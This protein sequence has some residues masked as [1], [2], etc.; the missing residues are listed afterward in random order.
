MLR[1]TLLLSLL[2]SFSSLFF[3]RVTDAHVLKSDGPI[4]AVVHI[5]PN[6]D[7]IVGEAAYFFFDFNDKESKFTPQNCSCLVKISEDGRE[8]FTTR[9]GSDPSLDASSFSYTFP[10]KGI[11]KITV[12][13]NSTNA[14]SFQPFTLE[15]DLRV[16]RESETK[17]NLNQ[18]FFFRNLQ[19]LVLVAIGTA[20]LLALFLEKR[21]ENV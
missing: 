1:K 19:Y 14:V 17:K 11:Y 7:P 15:Y 16:D 4:S 6:D 8:I 20:F 3:P 21:R 9:L 2:L 12:V 18:N 5:D 13:G 10:E